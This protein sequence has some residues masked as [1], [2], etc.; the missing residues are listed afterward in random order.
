MRFS[1]LLDQE[2]DERTG[3]IYA[4]PIRDYLP[5]TP[6]EVIEQVYCHHGRKDEFQSQYGELNLSAIDW[7][8]IAL[9]ASE[10]IEATIYEGFM[11]WFRNVE[12]R[13][14]EFSARGWQCIDTRADVIAHWSRYQTWMR[15]PVLIQGLPPEVT[16]RLHVMEGHTRVGLLKGLIKE[17]VLSPL[18][19]HEVFV[20]RVG[21][22]NQALQRTSR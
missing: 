8:S 20:G 7:T 15:P 21:A 18:S 5:E 16:G 22:P 12:S 10:I 2:Y 14:S 6:L 11:R 9:P 1:D 3:I 13:T 19:T 17:G 4:D